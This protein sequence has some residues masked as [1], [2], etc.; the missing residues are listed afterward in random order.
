MLYGKMDAHR[1]ANLTCTVVSNKREMRPSHSK[2]RTTSSAVSD[3]HMCASAPQSQGG[4]YMSS[5][6]LRGGDR[7]ILGA[8]RPSSL[9]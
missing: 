3:F 9:T 8:Y 7:R 1:P 2:P 6:H 4:T 5:Q